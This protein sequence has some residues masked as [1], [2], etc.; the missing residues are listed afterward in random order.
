MLGVGYGVWNSEGIDEAETTSSWKD[1]ITLRAETLSIAKCVTYLSA[2]GTCPMLKPIM[3]FVPPPPLASVSKGLARCRSWAGHFVHG[4]W[5][6]GF[7]EP[8]M[9]RRARLFLLNEAFNA[10]SSP[11]AET[12]ERCA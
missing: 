3:S 5:L 8:M 4:N 11:K 9:E 6:S 12:R 1:G 7:E 2:W 10:I